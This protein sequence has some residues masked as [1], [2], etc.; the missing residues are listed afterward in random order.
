MSR[1]G[2]AIYHRNDGLWEA[3]YVKEVDIYGK[4]KY[5]SVYGHSYRE[6]KDKRQDIV[7]RLLLC[8]GEVPTRRLTINALTKEWLLINKERLKK[9]SYQRYEGFFRNHIESIIGDAAA[10]YLTTTAV[11]SFSLNRLNAGLSPQSVN[12]VLIFLHSVM[13]YGHRQYHLPLPEFIYL[14]YDKKEMR[15]L[16]KEEQ[17]KLV[18]YLLCEPDAYK[19]GVLVALYTGLRIG[20]LCALHWDDVEENSIVVRRTVQRLKKDGALGTE[21]SISTPKT[22]ASCRTIPLPS[23]LKDYI[24][25]LRPANG[26]SYF[27]SYNITEPRVMQYK[28]KKYLVEAGINNAN[29]HALRHTFAT[30]CVEC[31][32]EIKSLSEILGHSNVQTTLNKYVHTSFELKQTNMERLASISW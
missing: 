32:F 23:F 15:V 13:K 1:R 4:K 7:D 14:A 12:A 6:A 9:S 3:R 21:L 8:Q 18:S 5:G 22:E 27:L 2:E 11:H 20:E 29:F 17:K 19:V 30:R 16:T 10:F 24:T 28:F 26:S 25:P 31:G